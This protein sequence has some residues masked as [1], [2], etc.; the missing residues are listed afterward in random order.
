MLT[1]RPGVVVAVDIKQRFADTTVAGRTDQ[2][3][4][5]RAR[6]SHVGRRSSANTTRDSNT[7]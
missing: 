1:F 7:F 2:R 4:I 6:H 5:W 3:H